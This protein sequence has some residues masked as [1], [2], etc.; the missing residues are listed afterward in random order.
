MNKKLILLIAIIVVSLALA[1]VSFLLLPEQVVVQVSMSGEASN[2][3]PKIL[4]VILPLALS[5]LCG[6]MYYTTKRGG[7]L[8]ASLIGLLLPVLT[9]IFNG[10]I[11]FGG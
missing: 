6:V 10:V 1:V 2:V 3:M 7:Y 9:L 5:V 8:A 11:K 4:A